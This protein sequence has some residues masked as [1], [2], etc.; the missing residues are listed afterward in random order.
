V[1]VALTG[2][3]R[4]CWPGAPATG[5]GTFGNAGASSCAEGYGPQIGFH[6]VQALQSSDGSHTTTLFGGSNS[7]FA[8]SLRM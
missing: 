7:S 6:F 5:G 8:V 4:R 3:V 1:A 2:L